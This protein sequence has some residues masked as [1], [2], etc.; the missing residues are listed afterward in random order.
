VVKGSLVASTA[1]RLRL[2]CEVFADAAESSGLIVGSCL[3][4]G[5]G[6]GT[7]AGAGGGGAGAGVGALGTLG[8]M[9][10]LT[11]ILAT[12]PNT[13]INTAGIL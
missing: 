12:N 1:L 7:A 13:G 9:S 8:R 10:A 4:S 11:A 3:G 2:V 6:V 5:G